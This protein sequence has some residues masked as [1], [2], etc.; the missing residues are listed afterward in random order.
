MTDQE[1][2]VN[3]F[4]STVTG[5]KR[6]QS[7]NPRASYVAGCMSITC[8][9]VDEEGVSPEPRVCRCAMNDGDGGPVSGFI[10]TWQG[11]HGVNRL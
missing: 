5:C 6:R 10:A 9:P 8:D 2:I 3:H 11:R 1:S 4:N 7:C